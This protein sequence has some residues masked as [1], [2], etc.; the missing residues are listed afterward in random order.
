M[1]LAET[2]HYRLLATCPDLPP[3]LK[4]AHW[5]VCKRVCGLE[6]WGVAKPGPT[7]F[8]QH[9]LSQGTGPLTCPLPCSGALVGVKQ[10]V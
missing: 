4:R 10:S 2:G 1:V 3:T 7:A 6:V 5:W 9:A 8:W